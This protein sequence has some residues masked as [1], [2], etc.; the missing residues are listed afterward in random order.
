MPRG[1]YKR[2]KKA[3]G[4]VKAKAKPVHVK[5]RIYATDDRIAPAIHDGEDAA[6]P[7]STHESG[8][9]WSK[10]E[11]TPESAGVSD[12]IN[13]APT[14]QERQLRKQAM[15]AACYSRGS[16]SLLEAAE[17][18]RAEKL[19]D[20]MVDF[21]KYKEQLANDGKA[22][23]SGAHPHWEEV[24]VD[25]KLFNYGGAA[26]QPATLN[27][28]V[29]RKVSIEG[30]N[31]MQRQRD[32]ALFKLRQIADIIDLVENRCLAADGP[33]TNTRHE[34]TDD[35]LRRIYVLAGGEIR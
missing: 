9:G 12:W 1:V 14:P 16:G 30:F 10:F 7:Q 25:P 11:V 19:R 17:K 5:R 28:P 3:K 13:A 20:Q 33:V 34:M 27:K 6:Q 35:E 31:A 8:G 26:P 32:N 4:K 21:N 24:P 29:E 2:T 18:L 22:L 15:H 23:F